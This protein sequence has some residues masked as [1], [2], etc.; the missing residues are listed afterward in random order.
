MIHRFGFACTLFAV[1]AA[2]TLLRAQ[3]ATEPTAIEKSVKETF[4]KFLKDREA[5][6][7]ENDP[8]KAIKMP[9]REAF[10]KFKSMVDLPSSVLAFKPPEGPLAW[11]I[12]PKKDQPLKGPA[13][14]EANK[15]ARALLTQFIR[16]ALY[17][18]FPRLFPDRKTDE[19]R[20]ELMMALEMFS[21]AQVRGPAAKPLAV[22]DVR[23]RLAAWLT[24]NKDAQIA[25][26][27]PLRKV[28]IDP[29]R[30][31]YIVDFAND[32]IDWTVFYNDTLPNVGAASPEEETETSGTVTALLG[33]FI[34]QDLQQ[35]VEPEQYDRI[36]A[37]STGKALYHVSQNF[38]KGSWTRW[39]ALNPPANRTA[40]SLRPTGIQP[41]A[42]QDEAVP[43]QPEQQQPAKEPR[44]A[45]LDDVIFDLRNL[46]YSKPKAR[47]SLS[48]AQGTTATGDALKTLE[49]QAAERFRT[50]LEG[51]VQDRVPQPEYVL[52]AQNF[53][54]T[55]GPVNNGQTPPAEAHIACG[56]F[57]GLGGCCGAEWGPAFWWPTYG[58]AWG[59]GCGGVPYL[60][61]PISPS[62]G[63]GVSGVAQPGSA[64]YA[65]RA[66]ST[67]DVRAGSGRSRSGD[68]LLISLSDSGL[69]APVEKLPD[70]KSFP[71]SP[72]QS[73]KWY[74]MGMDHFWKRDHAT[75]LAYLTAATDI[76]ND[77]RY[78]IFRGLSESR[79]NR[80]DDAKAS[81][82]KGWKLVQSGRSDKTT[83][84]NALERIQGQSRMQIEAV[85]QNLGVSW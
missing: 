16:D 49:G 17:Q 80:A 20:K 52:V 72:E 65:M 13:L 22:A 73:A 6:I 62:C 35:F 63:C 21:V 50:F 40:S 2:P 75:A 25:Q 60:A 48:L 79:M 23:A 74:A 77:A 45:T 70:F 47:W 37:N 83:L 71:A 12:L 4:D 43:Q 68:R 76:Q 85:R 11:Q 8:N 44:A 84:A 5:P 3:Q 15:Q 31:Q 34:D 29:A 69:A 33:D 7:E 19:E 46:I 27:A 54:V 1:A 66:G 39:L 53:E 61:Y 55:I 32:T 41:V 58:P 64:A 18:E 14:A 67:R 36:K 42:L 59:C 10:L 26:R 30:R 78:W 56:S 24:V 51:G 9:A 38:L 28:D 81:F 82:Q 57:F